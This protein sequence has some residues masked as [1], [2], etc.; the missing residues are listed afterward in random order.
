MKRHSSYLQRASSYDTK[1]TPLIDVV[2]LLLVFF[3]WTS[4][5]RVAEQWLPSRLSPEQGSERQTSSLPP[6]PEA[7]FETIYIGIE[8]DRSTSNIRFRINEQD[9]SSLPALADRLK[10]IREINRQAPIVIYPSAETQLGQV[11]DVYDLTRSLGFTKVQ[12]AVK[13][14]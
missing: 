11:I 12:F 4:S 3:V 14:E 9:V 2:F 7:D 13:T 1:L 6:P 10:V 8:G 5:F